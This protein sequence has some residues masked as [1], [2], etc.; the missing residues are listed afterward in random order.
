[1]CLI[2]CRKPL[3]DA[4]SF[5]EAATIAVKHLFN[6]IEWRLDLL[7]GLD[8]IF[9]QESSRSTSKFKDLCRKPKEKQKE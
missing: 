9:V 2:Y 4:R 5:L 6:P 8:M 1:M 7:A 3:K